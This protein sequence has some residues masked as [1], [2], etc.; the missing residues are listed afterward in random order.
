MKKR[1]VLVIISI[2]WLGVALASAQISFEGSKFIIR[3][4]AGVQRFI[5]SSSS[6][7]QDG[8]F[9][10]DY[11]LVARYGE[12]IYDVYDANM[13]LVK[14]FSISS[15]WFGVP[16][17]NSTSGLFSWNFIS[18]GIFTTDDKWACLV[19]EYEKQ[20]LKDKDG[21]ILDTKL[22]VKEL[23]IVNED[24]VVISTIPY[25]GTLI[26]TQ[27]LLSLVKIGDNYK[28]FVPTGNPSEYD[29]YA[30][31]GKGE[32]AVFSSPSMSNTSHTRKVFRDSQ[33]LVETDKTTFNI[34]GAKVE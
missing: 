7:E 12:P 31:P 26:Q 25:T 23:R 11:L 21:I 1:F 24:G 29:I 22:V 3:F 14:S 33:V 2:F 13:S 30:L 8:M 32:P 4:G 9:I 10:G 18:Q 17:D 27:T 34:Q 28:L 6:E 20:D 19:T 5:A 16:I 15:S